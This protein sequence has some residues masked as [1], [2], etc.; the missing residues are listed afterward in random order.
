MFHEKV[1]ENV[2]E[3]ELSSPTSIRD[4]TNSTIDSTTEHT[5]TARRSPALGHRSSYQV[6]GPSDMVLREQFGVRFF[7]FTL[8]VGPMVESTFHS[9]AMWAAVLM[10][11][12]QRLKCGA[13]SPPYFL[14]EL[15]DVT[16]EEFSK[17]RCL[18]S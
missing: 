2:I 15:Y 16:V 8:S 1:K 5:G 11:N 9:I 13:M 6:H 12:V 17:D 14:L 4:Q 3:L 18:L 10:F 7:P